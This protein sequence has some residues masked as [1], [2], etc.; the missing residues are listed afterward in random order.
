MGVH[1]GGRHILGCLCAGIAEYHAL[2]A[3]ADEVIGIAAV[4][5]VLDGVVDAHGDIG[6]LLVD[7]GHDGA[8]LIVKAIGGVGIAD[9]AD[10]LSYDAGDVDIAVG[11]HLAHDED[12][13]GRGDRLAC[14]TAVAVKMDDGVEDSV[15]D[16]VADLIGMSLCHAFRCKKLAAHKIIPF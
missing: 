16:L 13:A 10:G 2:V 12:H 15:G 3:G 8:G 6:R 14:N 5:A 9:I 4:A 11:R 1:D 7:G